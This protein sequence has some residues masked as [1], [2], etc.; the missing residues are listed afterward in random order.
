MGAP[1]ISKDAP[2]AMRSLSAAALCSGVTIE[3]TM[4]SA[5]A[6]A[7]RPERCT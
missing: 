5:P 7:V 2:S 3:M 6:L 1:S 4:P